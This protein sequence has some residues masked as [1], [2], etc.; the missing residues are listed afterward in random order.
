MKTGE[1]FKQAVLI[2]GL[3]E[4]TFREC[5]VCHTLLKFKFIDGELFFDSNCDCISFDTDLQPRTWDSLA[6]MYNNSIKNKGKF[7]KE[8]DEFFGFTKG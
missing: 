8:M 2:K 6:E 3:K 5:S 1:D 7:F 4:W